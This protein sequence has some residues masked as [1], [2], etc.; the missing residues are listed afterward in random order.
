MAGVVVRGFLASVSGNF[1]CQWRGIHNMSQSKMDEVYARP[2][3]PVDF[4]N[5]T[6]MT[7]FLLRRSALF[8]RRAR[9]QLR[10]LVVYNCGEVY[11][12]TDFA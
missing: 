5:I 2:F 12:F 3:I 10:Y 1:I 4:R 11:L 7:Q 6:K 8:E 9:D